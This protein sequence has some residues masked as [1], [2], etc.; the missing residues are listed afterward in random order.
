M[1]DLQVSKYALGIRINQKE[2]YTSLLQDKMISKILSEFQ[3]DK[4]RGNTSP[5][6]S[7]YQ[8]LKNTKLPEPEHPPFNYRH[9]IGLLQ[10]LVQCTQPYL[11]F[12]IS[13]LSQFLESPKDRHYQAVIHVLKYLNF[14]KNLELRIGCKELT[15]S[16]E[17]I[18]C[19]TD[20]DWG[21]AEENRSF[22]GS[23]IYYHGS[24]GWRSQK[25]C[26]VALSSAE[27]E[28]N[29]L[30]SFC[31]DSEW[32]CQLIFK[33]TN[34]KI[35]S[36]I[37]SDNSSSIALAS[38]CIYHHST[39]HIDF[40]LHFVCSLIEDKKIVLRYTPTQDMLA[41][42]LTKNL[43]FAKSHNLIKTIFGQE[44]QSKLTGMGE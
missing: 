35:T 25:Q 20:S 38:N 43:P 17:E 28:Y 39:R 2:H 9:V 36:I 16:L 7:N 5:I 29:A 11:T 23:I 10:Y 12:S 31:Q 1:E 42:L 30:S 27:A 40:R 33:I 18:I 34:K 19:F 6:P 13:F 3:V 21:G 14:T 41:D 15:H 32:I 24:L 26:V 44:I 4:S 8:E 22:S 37:Y